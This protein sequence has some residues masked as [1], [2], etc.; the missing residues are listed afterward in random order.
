MTELN[1]IYYIRIVF[2]NFF[3]VIAEPNCLWNYLVLVRSVS[4]GLPIPDRTVLGIM[5]GN[6]GGGIAEPKLFWN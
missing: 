3:S 1:F 2:G 5:F 6:L 4:T